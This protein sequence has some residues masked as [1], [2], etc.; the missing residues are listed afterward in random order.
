VSAS[1]SFVDGSL[2]GMLRFPDGSA[3]SLAYGTGESGRLEKE[4]IEVLGRHSAAVLDDFERLAVFGAGA[5][6][7]KGRRDKGHRAQLQAFV[8]AAAGR[9]PLPV[10][11]DEQL[12]VARAALELV[13]QTA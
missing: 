12:A 1:G 7:R 9:G 6:H 11:V 3:A 13:G 8:A 4:R 5:M 10:P 2:L